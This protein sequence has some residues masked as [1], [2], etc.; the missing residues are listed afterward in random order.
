MVAMIFTGW[1]V[2]LVDRSLASSGSAGVT[3]ANFGACATASIFLL[4]GV[5][6]ERLL[7]W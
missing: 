3:K 1:G 6:V 4:R 5:P 7:G 2:S